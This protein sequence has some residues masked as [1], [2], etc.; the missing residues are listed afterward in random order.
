MFNIIKLII[1]LKSAGSIP[2]TTSKLLKIAKSTMNMI[3]KIKNLQPIIRNISK[4]TSKGKRIFIVLTDS[5]IS[6][7]VGTPFIIYALSGTSMFLTMIS[8]FFAYLLAFERRGKF[9]RLKFGMIFLFISIVFFFFLGLVYMFE[10]VFNFEFDFGFIRISLVTGWGLYWMKIS[11]IFFIIG[12][13]F[14][15]LS[16]FI[17]SSDGIE[18]NNFFQENIN[19]KLYFPGILAIVCPLFHSKNSFYYKKNIKINVLTR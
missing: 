4:F 5:S 19:A 7:T 3:S 17:G 15:F 11:S 8:I 9:D 14:I 12:F 18:E 13:L 2:M 10:Y 6:R 16:I 1:L